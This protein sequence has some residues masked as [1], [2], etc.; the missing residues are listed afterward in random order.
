VSAPN[1]W[2]DGGR[3]AAIPAAVLVVLSNLVLST[4]H[5]AQV[6][7]G[8]NIQVDQVSVYSTMPGSDGQRRLSVSFRVF[9]NSVGSIVVPQPIT[10]RVTFAG[11][12]VNLSVPPLASQRF[13]FASTAIETTA[14]QVPIVYE[15]GQSIRQIARRQF[16]G[17]SQSL[18]DSSLP[19]C[20]SY[21]E[22]PA[23]VFEGLVSTGEN[24]A[25]GLTCHGI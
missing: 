22:F 6:G 16:N 18:G 11:N 3:N 8:N 10:A 20:C 17:S 14:T 1:L 25:V 12:A 24:P 5:T 9:N 2:R 21:Q 13:A 4:A 15:I 7:H 23:L 19:D